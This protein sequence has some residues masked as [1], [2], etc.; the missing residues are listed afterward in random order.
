MRQFIAILLIQFI[1]CFPSVADKTLV[2]DLAELR[3]KAEQG[4]APAQT[5]L[6]LIYYIGEGVERDYA[7]TV[8][9]W[10]AAAAKGN[11]DA[12]LHPRP[13]CATRL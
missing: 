8:K 7:E 10:R 5:R 12:A 11:A 4:D 13:G 1:L 9:W 3:A 2:N 6:G